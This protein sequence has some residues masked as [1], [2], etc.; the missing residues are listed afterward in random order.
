MGFTQKY[1]KGFRGWRRSGEGPGAPIPT[2]YLDLHSGS[3][4]PKE[5]QAKSSIR[6]GFGSEKQNLK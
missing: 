5:K 6:T 1:L 4:C 3:L 2:E